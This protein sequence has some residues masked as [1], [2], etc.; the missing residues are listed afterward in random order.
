MT[1]LAKL[2]GVIDIQYRS[3]EGSI[4]DDFYIPCMAESLH[5]R[6]AVSYFSS[7]GLAIAARGVVHLLNNGGRIDLVCSPVLK[8][9][10]IEAIRVGYENRTAI[11]T[12]ILVSRFEDLMSEEIRK[13]LDAL[14]WLIEDNHLEIKL[15]I[16]DASSLEKGLYHEKIGVFSD[17]NGNNIAFSGSSNE[18]FGGLVNNFES[19]DVY[20]S[21][22]DGNRVTRK[23]EAFRK[24]WENRTKGLQIIP[25]TEA[26]KEIL[27]PYRGTSRPKSEPVQPP[28]NVAVERKWRH[29]D[30]AVEEFLKV[31]RGVLN[32]A[33]GTG[34]TRTALR[35]CEELVNQD[36]V[37]S[38]IVTTYGTDLLNQWSNKLIELAKNIEFVLLR[39]YK[40]FKERDR[41]PIRPGKKILLISRQELPDILKRLKEQHSKRMIVIHDEVHRLGSPAN[42]RDLD[43]LSEMIRFRLGLSATWIREYDEAGTTFIEEHIGKEFYSFGIDKA[44]EN[45]ILS[46]FNYFPLNYQLTE[47]DRKKYHDVWKMVTAR[48]IAGDPMS[49]EQIWMHL[50]MIPKTSRAK[51]PVFREFV[52]NNPEM[53]TRCIIFVHTM[54]YGKEVLEIVHEF[55]NDFRTY[56]SQEDSNILQ[57]FA[58]G[59]IECLIT[60]HRLSEGIDIQS[61]TNVVLFSS[62]R[63]KLETIQRIG[64]CL[65][66]D[67]DNPTK[68][69]NIIDFIREEGE[70]EESDDIPGADEERSTFLNEL[71]QIRTQHS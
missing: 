59:E 50:S 15:A 18:T 7:S 46:P 25:F 63:A 44:I 40:N 70:A 52:R 35:I 55:R 14:A 56:F 67:P 23:I 49:Q 61:V 24:L 33:T 21:W 42:Q 37:D 3:D 31:E 66:I 47:E 53:L 1:D 11:V 51:L 64:R 43:G 13:Q 28:E 38:I 69:A 32:M 39:H 9:E 68:V 54:E 2:R 19:I 36:L 58:N 22:S 34:K 10:D 29:Q 6:R 65:R 16:R 12:D 26:T 45:G 30:E 4:L 60:C 27:R 5:Y 71:S 48:K 62:D 57:R 17:G 20:C 41:F 8:E